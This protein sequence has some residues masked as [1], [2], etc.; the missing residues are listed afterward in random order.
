MNDNKNCSKKSFCEK[1]PNYHRCKYDNDNK[2]G[3]DKDS[4]DSNN[5]NDSGSNG[6]KTVVQS[7]SAIASAN[8]TVVVNTVNG[9]YICS[10]EGIAD[11]THQA[12][13]LMKYKK[14]KL[15]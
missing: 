2:N 5:E 6:D 12:F 8:A 14:V 4:D 10:L 13:D 11:A 9:T 1:N 15:S 7:A 3:Y